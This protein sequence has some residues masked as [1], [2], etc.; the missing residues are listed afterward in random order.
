MLPTVAA[1]TPG[2]AE[3]TA[4]LL[5]RELARRRGVRAMPLLV[6]KDRFE[7]RASMEPVATDESDLDV[8]AREAQ[9]ALV[10]VATGRNAEAR[11]AVRRVLDRAERALESLNRE[12]T[13]AR[14]IL[15]ACLYLV[16]ATLDAGR[17]AR[18]RARVLECRRLVPDVTPDPADH[19]PSVLRILEEAE[20]ELRRSS[21]A[22]LRVDS[23]PPGCALYLNGRHLGATPFEIGDL[24]PGEYRVQVECGGARLSRVHRLVLADEP[25]ELSIDTGLDEAI[26]SREMLALHYPSAED[27]AHRRL[28][29]GARVADVVGAAHV[30]LVTAESDALLRLDRVDG[31]TRGVVA[32]ARVRVTGRRRDDRA[33]VARA[34]RALAAGRSVDLAADPAREIAPWAPPAPEAEDAL[35]APVAAA[36]AASPTEGGAPTGPQGA[37]EHPAGRGLDGARVAG[38]TLFAGGIAA[39]VA[40]WALWGELAARR[41]ALDGYPSMQAGF[42]DAQ[43]DY[44]ALRWPTALVGAG[45]AVLVGAAVPLVLEDADGVPAWAWVLGAVG[46]GGVGAGV[47]LAVSEGPCV[48][49]DCTRRAPRETLGALV[50]AHAAPLLAV[51]LTLAVRAATGDDTIEADVDLPEAGLALRFRGRW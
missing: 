37:T 45:G 43:A 21:R 26:R 42:S 33:V 24:P 39:Y 3:E 6:A 27:E 35:T 46:L 41:D 49:Q 28:R 11:A 23:D 25:T 47:G 16:R 5:Q 20:A 31:P 34:A 9:A 32:T 7:A 50:A 40:S 10:L 13:S 2:L 36:G 19:P 44:D 38:W 8:V 29:D 30:V 4:P 51:P 22:E 1:E 14:R 17:T 15:D 12:T 18:A 48:D